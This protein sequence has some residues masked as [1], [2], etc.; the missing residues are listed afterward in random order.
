M[1]VYSVDESIDRPKIDF[2]FRNRDNAKKGE[3]AYLER[4]KAWLHSLG[5]TGPNTGRMLYTPFADGA[6]VYMFAESANKRTAF[7]A[8]IDIGD[9]WH[10][11]LVDGLTKKA[12]LDY[13]KRDEKFKE[14]WKNL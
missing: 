13:I 8:H 4:V 2:S 11:P 1:K 9:A 3:E 10:N 7:L 14:M 6:A 5:Y 12:V